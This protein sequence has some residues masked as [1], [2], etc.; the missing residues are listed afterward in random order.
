VGVHEVSAI[1]LVQITVSTKISGSEMNASSQ[2]TP[3]KAC[4]T[5]AP[6]TLKIGTPTNDIHSGSSMCASIVGRDRRGTACGAQRF[7]R[8]VNSSGFASRLTSEPTTIIVTPHHSDH[9]LTISPREIGT[10]FAR[11]IRVG[12]DVAALDHDRRQHR[13]IDKRAEQAARRHADAHQPADAQHRGVEREAQAELAHIGA[14]DRG[15]HSA[16]LPRRS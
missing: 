8:A 9:W 1:E 7:E 11:G 2:G 14:E 10:T 15:V 3:K 13:E 12:L 16:Y 4:V 6:S 5:H